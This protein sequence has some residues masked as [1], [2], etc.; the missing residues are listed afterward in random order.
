MRKGEIINLFGPKSE[1]ESRSAH[2]S[3]SHIVPDAIK[4]AAV[5]EIGDRLVQ[6]VD[7]DSSTTTVKEVIEKDLPEPTPADIA[8]LEDPLISEILFED[9]A[10]GLVIFQDSLI[11]NND[12]RFTVS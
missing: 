8:G 6:Q 3:Q 10:E 11:F 1:A 2:P 7:Q 9:D 4:Y 12:N 5:L